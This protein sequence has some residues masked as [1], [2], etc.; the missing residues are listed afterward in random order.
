MSIKVTGLLHHGVRVGKNPEQVEAVRSFYSDVL[1][2][3]ADEERPNIRGVP[4]FWM[5]LGSGAKQQ[6]HL[7]GAEGPSPFAKSA[8]EDPVTPHVA[9]A[10]ED[11]REAMSV[12]VKQE[13]P[14]FTLGNIIGSF[15]LFV[16]DPAGNMVELQ[17]AAK[18]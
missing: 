8:N 7:M 6:I 14:Y 5:N 3:Q 18:E 4:G 9:L 1:G 2:L 17:E 15:Q 11:L 13:I 10:V 12:M 16:R